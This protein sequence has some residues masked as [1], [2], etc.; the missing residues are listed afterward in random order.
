MT[1]KINKFSSLFKNLTSEA[2]GT[3]VGWCVG[4]ATFDLLGLFLEKKGWFNLWG[5]WTDKWAVEESTFNVI[6]WIVAALVG[7]IIMSVINI[8]LIPLIKLKVTEEK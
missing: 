5:Y 2:L 3:G 6:H 8:Y 1:T 4:L 7:F